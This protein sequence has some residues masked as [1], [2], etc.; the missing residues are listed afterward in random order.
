[1]RRP[2]QHPAL[3]N[4]IAGGTTTADAT[5]TDRFDGISRRKTEETR[6]NFEQ[7][8]GSQ[9][10][11]GSKLIPGCDVS[12]M[13]ASQWRTEAQS[14]F[15]DGDR[16]SKRAEGKKSVRPANEAGNYIV[17]GRSASQVLHQ[18]NVL[19]GGSTS[20]NPPA[21][22]RETPGAYNARSAR[23]NRILRFA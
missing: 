11:S 3:A 1:V 16:P 4:N 18:R 8:H 20:G 17:A 21:S 23:D 9:S 14:A 7:M 6:V 19:L 10:T 15:T 13:N 12:E 2:A 22:K 5:E